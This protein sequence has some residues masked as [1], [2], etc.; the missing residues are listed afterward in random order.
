MAGS[1]NGHDAPGALEDVR[2]LLNTWVIPNHT[3]RPEDHFDEYAIGH[4]LS[5]S[6]QQLMKELRDDLR[7][8][9]GRAADSAATVNRWIDRLDI[10]PCVSDEGIEFTHRSGPAGDIVSAVLSAIA[11]RRWHRLKA[12]PDCQ[13]VFYDHSRNASKRWCLMSAGGPDGRS[14]GS[15]AKVRAHRERTGS[16]L[17]QTSGTPLS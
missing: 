17:R 4:R 15:I 16:K 9:V 8:V 3:R 11:D 7:Q 1:V 10:R 5:A 13:W 6:R 14:C 12:C 2:T